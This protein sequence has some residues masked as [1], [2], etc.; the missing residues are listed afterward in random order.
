MA[1]L[2]AGRVLA[3][4]APTPAGRAVGPEAPVATRAARLAIAA[5]VAYQLLL[6]LLILL[7]PDLDPS[8]RTLSEWALGRHGW[9]MSLAFL[10]SALSYGSLFVALARQARGWLGRIGLGILAL[11]TL[12][13]A[14]AG[15]FT[16]DPFD[17]PPDALSV[18]GVAHMLSA[19]VGLMS[20]PFAAALLN[21]DLARR[22]GRW[23]AVRRRLLA[24]AALPLAGLAAFWTH[25]T[26]AV[27][28]LDR[29]HGPGVPLGWPPRFLLLAY[30]IWLI[31]LASSALRVA[32]YRRVA[33]GAA[34]ARPAPPRMTS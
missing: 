6:A 13:T 34:S 1:K 19:F 22:S 11:S 27:L 2:G 32:G 26:V 23:S 3:H 14:G 16:T 24:T 28:P 15:I 29:D 20:L 33:A 9:L 7:R 12:G 18:T 30:A 5:V 17:T 10:L 8:W 31:T 21:L 4:D 25:L